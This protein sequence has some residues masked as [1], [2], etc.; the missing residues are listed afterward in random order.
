MDSIGEEETAKDVTEVLLGAHQSG[1]HRALGVRWNL[2]DDTLRFLAPPTPNIATRRGILSHVM[3]IFDPLGL[4]SPCI[5]RA[6]SLLQELC[7]RQLG[8]DEEVDDIFIRQWKAWRED[9]ENVENLGIPRHCGSYVE[10]GGRAELHHFSDASE[11]GYGACSYLRVV[12][13]TGTVSCTLVYAKS[14]VTPLKVQ[15]IPRLELQAAVQA[16]QVSAHLRRELRTKLAT[17]V[18]W[19][20]SKVVLGYLHNT[21]KRFHTFVANRVQQIHQLTEERQ[22]KYVPSADNPADLASRGTTTAGLNNSIWFHGPRFL[23]VAQV[24]DPNHDDNSPVVLPEVKCILATTAEEKEH[25]ITQFNVISS[26]T[27]MVKVLELVLRK[28][29]WV[30]RMPDLEPPDLKQRACDELFRLSQEETL[31][32]AIKQLESGGHTSLNAPIST[33]NPFLSQSGLIHVGG[34]LESA[35]L[36]TVIKHP[37]ILTQDC[38][39]AH[40]L[41][42]DAH[43]AIGHG[44]RSATIQALRNRGVWMMRARKLVDSIIFKCVTCRKLNRRTQVQLMG[45]LPSER[46]EPAAPF[47]AVGC[48]MFGPFF[49][50]DRRSEL[51]RYGVLFTC[52][53]SRAVHIEVAEELSTDSFINA[54]RRLQ[55]VR[56]PVQQVRCDQGTNFV[57]AESE[58]KRKMKSLSCD[59]T[60]NVPHDSH[61]GGVWERQIRSARRILSGLMTKHQERLSTEGLRT[62]LYEVTYVINSRP[63][64]APSPNDWSDPLISPNLLLTGKTEVIIPFAADNQRGVCAKKMWERVQALTNIFWGKW[65]QDYLSDQQSRRKWKRPAQNFSIGD[66]VLVKDEQM[67]RCQWPMGRLT[68]VTHSDDGIV[69]AVEVRLATRGRD[70]HGKPIFSSH[71][72]RRPVQELVLILEDDGGDGVNLD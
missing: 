52:L 61:A 34:R 60:F 50:K 47:T 12:S 48:D 57:G 3:G 58:L 14:K 32:D 10:D 70:R 45:N 15:T 41:V 35:N 1:D 30:K 67:G 40:A 71:M 27:T 68:R 37:I 43:A 33:L 55:S 42:N 28:Q 6:K 64:T 11:S 72:L 4:I 59:F 8:W 25:G 31:G 44:G 17:E 39:I 22:W 65:R 49:I 53:S 66:I 63:L 21:T 24:E 18:F 36:P 56:G 69:R 13:T 16:A 46:V 9:F 2:A 7:R 29:R 23:H 54:F 26:W 20:D 5:L 38:T 62:L 19:T 51:K